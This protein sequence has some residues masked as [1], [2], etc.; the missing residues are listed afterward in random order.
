MDPVTRASV[1]A[2]VE[3]AERAYDNADPE[4][5]AHAKIVVAKCALT[6]K[7]FTSDDVWDAGLPRT[8]ENRALG[9]IMA[10][11]ARRGVIRDTGRVRRGRKLNH[12]GD[13]ARVWESM[14]YT[15][16]DP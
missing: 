5:K 9:P 2:G 14:I 13:V 12:H 10:R 6:M 3:A 1:M 11:A 16:V 8:R 7:E 15:E 4:W